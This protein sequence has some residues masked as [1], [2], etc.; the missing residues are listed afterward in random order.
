MSR[1]RWWRLKVWRGSY[2]HAAQQLLQRGDVGQ[3]PLEVLRHVLEDGLS[4]VVA[5][6][7]LLDAGVDGV[8]TLDGAVGFSSG[9]ADLLVEPWGSRSEV[10]GQ[11]WLG[12]PTVFLPFRL[13]RAALRS[14]EL[15]W[16]P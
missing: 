11:G 14:S 7:G 3:A 12:T 1:E 5:A 9:A 13:L 8:Q 6:G 10:R 4:L 2:L 15:P 16:R